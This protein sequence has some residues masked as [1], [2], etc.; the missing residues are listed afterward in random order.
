MAID[1]ITLS[2]CRVELEKKIA[3]ARIDK[4]YQ[5]KDDFLTLRLRHQGE[6]PVLLTVIDP[7]QARIHLTDI[8]FSNPPEPPVFAM[9]LRKY[10]RSGRIK[11]I[12]QPGMERML[13]IVIENGQKE[14]RLIAEIMGRYSNVI[15]VDGE[16]IVLDAMKRITPEDDSSRTLMPNVRYEP[17]PPQNKADPYQLK[18][19]DWENMIGDDFRKY[20]YRAILNNIQGFG[21]DMA[22]EIIYRAGADPEK[23][24]H[25]LADEKK[26]KIKEKLF[27]FLAR[28]R[29]E[30]YEPALGIDEEEEIVY[31]SA[32]PLKHYEEVEHK[33]FAEISRLFDYYYRNHIIR[34]DRERKRKRLN[35]IIERYR[36]KNEEQQRKIRG[37]L[38]QSQQ[39]DKYKRRGELLKA[40]LHRVEKGQKEVEVIDY[41]QEDQPRVTIP[42]DGDISPG[43]NVD[44]LFKK[45]DKLKK[46]RDHLV[47]ELAKLRHEEKYLARVELEI[48][49]AENMADMDEIEEELVAE[50]YIQKQNQKKSDIKQKK[51]RPRQFYS[52]DGYQILVG[53]NNRQNDRLTNKTASDKDIWVHAR[54]IAGSHVI[55]RNHRPHR[56]I[57]RSTIEEAAILA[58]YYSKARQSE[59]VPVDYAKIPDVKKPRGAKPGIVYYENHSTLYVDPDEEEV[60]EIASREKPEEL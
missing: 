29:D 38:R 53:R 43:E 19:T 56:E 34:K 24:Y 10:L 26:A 17:P 45:Y 39:A 21:P 20:A 30:N 52:Q 36:E 28:I 54:K 51:S 14:Y 60:K 7:R 23:N 58:A 57:P 46:S 15:L 33:T 25:E 44:K 50:N 31:Q 55:I 6:N 4:A 37:K 12:D 40:N 3:G 32:Y 2:L 59:N 1:G 9:V 42:L 5:P 35:D 27:D 49:Q 16:G 22:R 8:N 18:K 13:E 47:K 41:Y 11:R 48:E